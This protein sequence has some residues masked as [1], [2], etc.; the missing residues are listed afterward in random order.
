MGPIANL[1]ND[2]ILSVNRRF[3]RKLAD[4][5]AALAVLFRSLRDA[6]S[7]G[8][9]VIFDMALPRVPAKL[10]HIVR[11]H[12][13]DE[14]RHEGM[15]EE[16][17]ERLGHRGDSDGGHASAVPYIDEAAGTILTAAAESDLELGRAYLLVYAL[18]RRLSAQL[19]QLARGIEHKRP[20]IAAMVREVAEDEKKHI[21]WC[22]VVSY[23]LIGDADV[24]EAERQAMIELETRTYPRLLAQNLNAMLDEGLTNMSRAER[25]FWRG[26]AWFAGRLPRQP[27]PDPDGAIASRDWFP[28]ELR[29]AA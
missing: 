4:D 22:G 26:A 3:T 28:R 27:V 12:A 19:S 11:T 14:E 16:I 23:H 18:E 13:A 20:E 1:V 5:P 8:E 10:V 17:L 25:F 2:V 7:D 21:G 24:W 9:S 29:Q 15:M 6:E